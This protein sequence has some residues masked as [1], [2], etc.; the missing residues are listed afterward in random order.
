MKAGTRIAA[1]GRSDFLNRINNAVVFPSVLRALLDTRAK[2][3][4]EDML[5]A[6]S[7]AIASLV[8]RPHLN[9]EYII[10]KVNDPRIL[11]IVIRTLKD[12]RV[13]S[14]IIIMVWFYRRPKKVLHTKWF[15][16]H[17]TINRS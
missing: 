14:I 3:L 2:G 13:I 5:V 8:E 6:A 9:D 10:P 17:K 4:D 16:K 7:C 12:A 1:S 11:P 15:T